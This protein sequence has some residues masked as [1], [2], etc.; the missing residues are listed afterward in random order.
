MAPEHSRPNRG[1][2]AHVELA[3]G[4]LRLDVAIEVG[5]GEVLALIGPNGAGKTTLLRA[6]AGLQAIDGGEVRLDATVLEAPREG[7]RLDPDR[8]GVGFVPQDHVLFEHLDVLGNVAFGP[9]CRGRSGAASEATARGWLDRLDSTELAGLRP[10][11]LS[12]GQSQRVALARALAA[13]PALLLLDEP[14][15]ALDATTRVGV[16]GELRRHLSEFPGPTV[17]VTHDPVDALV[18][19]ERIAVMEAGRITQLGSASEVASHPRT[20][21]VAD[22]V[23]LNLLSGE[24]SAE[25]SGDL[26]DLDGGAR[27]RLADRLGGK[28]RD[29]VLVV[30]RPSAVSLHPDRPQTSARNAWRFTVASLDSLGGHVRVGLAGDFA[31][32]AEVTPAAVAELGLA[33]GQAV[34][35]SV[36]ATEVSAFAAI[37]GS[38]PSREP[39]DQ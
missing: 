13:E 30:I 29:P 27:L 12:G 9:R 21:Y 19:A 1:L 16:R 3:L 23:G 2:S 32:V 33:E 37:G 14:M 15:A 34:W 25:G 4:E 39:E 26:V 22:L 6:L 20:K 38:P 8:R 17:V 7:T 28:A 5:P 36:K 35:A 31:L 10:A 18:L 11:E 24:R